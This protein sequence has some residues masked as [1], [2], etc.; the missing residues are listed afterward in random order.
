LNVVKTVTETHDAIVTSIA[1]VS[2][3]WYDRL[4]ADLQ[5]IL[6]EEGEAVQKELFDWTV[7]FNQ[8]GRQTWTDKGGELIKLSPPDQAEMMKR[9]STVGEEVVASQPRLKEIYDLMVQTARSRR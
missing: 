7:D 5:K 8:K 1:M 4:P 9:L 3:A 6:V 2:K